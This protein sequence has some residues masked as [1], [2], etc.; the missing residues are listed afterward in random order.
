MN[1]EKMGKKSKK[2]KAT[3]VAKE[4]KLSKKG[5]MLDTTCLG[6]GNASWES[7]YNLIEAEEP[8]ELEE[9]AT[10]DSTSKSEGTLKELAYSCLHKIVAW[11]KILPYTDVVRWVVKK[12]RTSDRTFST[13]DRRIFRSFKLEDLRKMYHL[14][15]PKKHYNK[16]FL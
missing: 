13:A 4:P 5:L 2:A 1:P 14:P 8:E 9:E 6:L 11:A 12:I 10:V 16:A 7:I 3:P 15:P